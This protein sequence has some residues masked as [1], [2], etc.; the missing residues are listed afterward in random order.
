MC[1]CGHCKK[2]TPE[3]AAAAKSLAE[4]GAPAKLAK[5]RNVLIDCLIVA[6]KS[7]AESGSPAKLAKVRNVLID[8]LIVAAKSLAESGSPA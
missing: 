7:L 2:L 8:G 3:Y 1:R 5:V 4:S 6:A